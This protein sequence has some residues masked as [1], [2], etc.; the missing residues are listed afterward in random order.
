MELT[1][2]HSLVLNPESALVATFAPVPLTSDLS[3]AHL[4]FTSSRPIS[5]YGSDQAW[6]L[7]W[8]SQPPTPQKE[9]NDF[10]AHSATGHQLR[11]Q[12]QDWRAE[13]ARRLIVNVGPD[14][15]GEAKPHFMTFLSVKTGLF[16]AHDYPKYG[17]EG[18]EM[19][20]TALREFKVDP[21]AYLPGPTLTVRRRVAHRP[22]STTSVTATGLSGEMDISRTCWRWKGQARRSGSTGRTSAPRPGHRL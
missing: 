20:L 2:R 10:L 13:E 11:V 17:E 15:A 5:A 3:D 6:P 4:N 22:L 9:L 19:A 8:G 12:M 21:A 1:A 7:P 18:F 16:G 14:E